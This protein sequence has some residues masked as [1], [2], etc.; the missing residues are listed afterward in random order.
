ML[1]AYTQ[2]GKQSKR[3]P[4]VA[5]VPNN[6]SLWPDVAYAFYQFGD[7]NQKNSCIRRLLHSTPVL[8]RQKYANMHEFRVKRM[9]LTTDP[10]PRP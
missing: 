10:Y 7:A 8:R 9:I 2:E 3:K 6:V 4:N 1:S 5:S